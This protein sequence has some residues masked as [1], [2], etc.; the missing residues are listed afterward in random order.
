MAISLLIGYRNSRMEDRLVPIAS[1]D[2]FLQHWLP[3]CFE[4]KLR[5][6]SRFG[7]GGWRL[8]RSD[9]PPILTE[10]NRLKY[11]LTQQ[12][13]RPTEIHTYMLARI[14]VLGHE[15]NEILNT[16]EAEA[17]V[18]S[19]WQAQ[20]RPTPG[21]SVRPRSR[22]FRPSTSVQLGSGTSAHQTAGLA[23]TSLSASSETSL[24]SEDANLSEPEISETR[25]HNPAARPIDSPVKQWWASLMQNFRESLFPD[26]PSSWH[27]SI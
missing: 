10:L 12:V 16:T 9:I 23:L 19:V 17:F 11:H 2:T 8:T 20:H 26:T 14:G 7:T 3:L 4:L 15:F 13:E 27:T 25:S 5:W 6:V 24:P 21:L 22:A 18:G 1:D